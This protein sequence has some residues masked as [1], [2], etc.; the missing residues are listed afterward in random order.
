MAVTEEI[1]CTPLVPA[2]LTLAVVVAEDKVPIL[3]DI[4]M[5]A[6]V[7]RASSASGYTKNK[8]GLRFGGR[9]RRFIWQL[10]AGR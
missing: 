3:P 2:R 8:H 4:L 1:I 5:A 10:Q 7:A 9:E 6:P